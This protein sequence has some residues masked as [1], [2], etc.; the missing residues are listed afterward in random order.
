MKKYEVIPLYL[1][2]KGKRVFNDGD[3]VTESDFAPDSIPR[4]LAGGYIKEI[5]EPAQQAVLF[6]VVSE[7]AVEPAVSEPAAVTEPAAEPAPTAKP[8]PKK[9]TQKKK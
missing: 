9:S 1:S 3:I 2:G 6:P 8:A 4:L 7:P 5:S